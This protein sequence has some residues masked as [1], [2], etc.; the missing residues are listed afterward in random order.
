[1]LISFTGVKNF[2][3]QLSRRNQA[4]SGKNLV[5]SARSDLAASCFELCQ[6]VDGTL[7]LDFFYQDKHCNCNWA[8]V[9]TGTGSLIPARAN[10]YEIVCKHSLE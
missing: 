1:M 6:G 4:L 2:E 3:M 8:S 9:R 5:T 10:Y 7:S